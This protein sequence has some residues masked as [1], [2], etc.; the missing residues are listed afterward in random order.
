MA[1]NLHWQVCF[2]SLGGT[3]YAVNIYEQSY[4]GS[5]V[6]LTG[7]ASPFTTQEE[8]DDDY[9]APVRVQTGYLRV[10]DYDGTLLEQIIPANNTQRLVRL[11]YGTYSGTWPNGTFTPSSAS[12]ALQWQG[13]LMADAFT[14]P[15]DNNANEIELP[16]RSVIGALEDVTVDGDDYGQLKNVASIIKSGFD[17]LN[18]TPDYVYQ[19]SDIYDFFSNVMRMNINMQQFVKREVQYNEGTELT[20]YNGENYLTVIESVMALFGLQ[21]REH[22]GNIYMTM[23]DNV[24]SSSRVQ[25]ERLSWGYFTMIAGGSVVYP[26]YIGTLSD[27]TL[28]TGLQYMGQDNEKSFERGV[29][30]VKAELKIE[31]YNTDI[32]QMPKVEEDASQV[33]TVLLGG[34]NGILCV[35]PHTFP[36]GITTLYLHYRMTQ[37]RTPPDYEVHT[38]FEYNS[39]SNYNEVLNMSSIIS[40]KEKHFYSSSPNVTVYDIYTGAIPVRWFIKKGDEPI[41]LKAGWYCV[42]QYI[43]IQ[44]RVDDYSCSVILDGEIPLTEKR[45]YLCIK[46]SMLTFI[47]EQLAETGMRVYNGIVS[48]GCTLRNGTSYWN[49]SQWVPAF[50]IFNLKFSK[51]TLRSNKSDYPDAEG[52]DGYYVPFSE[53]QTGSIYLSVYNEVTIENLNDNYE[54]YA[55]IISDVSVSAQFV[56]SDYVSSSRTS[57]TYMLNDI[58]QGASGSKDISLTVGTNNNNMPSP[59]FIKD[60]RY[61]DVEDVEYYTDGGPLM[62][63][64]PER[65]LIYRM[66]RQYAGI[67]RTVSMQ[68]Q[69]VRLSAIDVMTT[70]WSIDGHAYFGVLSTREWR[71]DTDTVKFIEV[72]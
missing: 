37:T 30:D 27:T 14:Q 53:G 2:A 23:F 19:V 68:I 28:P 61:S 71:D 42:H 13:F 45:G 57:N 44:S 21:L 66:Q 48:L 59:S 72:S 36:S 43:G 51:G 11:Y 63:E 15:I 67:R 3:Q 22:G 1:W 33:H 70:R 65:H 9:F 41:K 24:Y 54:S 56:D 40:G 5:V 62:S 12:N 64:R 29:R 49:G 47:L 31:S 8:D 17:A 7:S 10:I 55:S 60:Y 58:S 18:V 46:M 32:I 52:G 16:I 34:G 25:I 35:Q 26:T 39:Q 69:N 6:Q 50:T 38:E 4:S 20:V